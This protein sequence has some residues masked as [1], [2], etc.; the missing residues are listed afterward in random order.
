[1]Y[2]G[3]HGI[4][5]VCLP[6]FHLVRLPMGNS[7]AL[8]ILPWKSLHRNTVSAVLSSLLLLLPAPFFALSFRHVRQRCSVTD[9]H[10]CMSYSPSIF[11]YGIKDSILQRLASRTVEMRMTWPRN[12]C[13][14]SNAESFTKSNQYFTN[15][16][17][18][19]PADATALRNKA[20]LP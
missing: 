6:R 8:F 14:A 2:S 15:Q 4:C 17:Q 13:L 12:L 20:L 18:P 9:P 19:C 10:T 1:M 7:I 5:M 16:I 11:S 3:Y